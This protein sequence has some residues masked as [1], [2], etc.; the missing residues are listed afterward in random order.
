[1]NDELPTFPTVDLALAADVDLLFCHR[2]T[3]GLPSAG[4]PKAEWSAGAV[5][6]RAADLWQDDVREFTPAERVSQEEVRYVEAMILRAGDAT[7]RRC[8]ATQV[9][10][11]FLTR[12]HCI[13][14]AFSDPSRFAA[15]LAPLKAVRAEKDERWRR[16]SALSAYRRNVVRREWPHLWVGGPSAEQDPKHVAF[17]FREIVRVEE[18][19]KSRVLA[20]FV[21]ESEAEPD[22]HLE[23]IVDEADETALAALAENFS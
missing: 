12:Q 1:M 18:R 9:K 14:L 8:Q 5:E 23:T 13:A 10:G 15:C 4:A 11:H 19:Y 16:L 3:K 2:K 6:A 21:R 7:A 20:R 17:T 22:T